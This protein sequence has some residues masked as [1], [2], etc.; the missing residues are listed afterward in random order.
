M[1]PPGIPLP[2]WM[3]TPIRP[4]EN[5][6]PPVPEPQRSLLCPALTTVLD[7]WQDEAR[8]EIHGTTLRELILDNL[9]AAYVRGLKDGK[10]AALL[11]QQM[12]Q[13]A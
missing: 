11:A 3:L 5:P 10:D 7:G 1:I 8:I 13:G 6:M 2:A 9:T 12:E 4:P